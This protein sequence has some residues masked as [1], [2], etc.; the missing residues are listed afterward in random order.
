MAKQEQEKLTQWKVLPI[1][2]PILREELFPEQWKKYLN[3]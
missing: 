1:L 2:I 3:L